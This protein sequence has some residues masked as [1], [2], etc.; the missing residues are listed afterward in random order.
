MSWPRYKPGSLKK[1][2]VA[3]AGVAATGAV[4]RYKSHSQG[5][6][7]EGGAP[8]LEEM[9]EGEGLAWY[10]QVGAALRCG[11]VPGA[12][13]VEHGRVVSPARRRAQEQRPPEPQPPLP[14]ATPPYRRR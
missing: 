1:V 14:P 11:R 3:F 2:L 4:I 10:L 8:G 7:L 6:Q 5:R 13:G 12:R 9:E